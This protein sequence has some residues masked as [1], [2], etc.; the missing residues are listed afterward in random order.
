MRCIFPLAL[1]I[2]EDLDIKLGITTMVVEHQ[3]PSLMQIM[4]FSKTRPTSPKEYITLAVVIH[5]YFIRWSVAGHF[6]KYSFMKLPSV[7]ELHEF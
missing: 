2:I 3:D 5:F 1:S 7:H 4:V 6:S